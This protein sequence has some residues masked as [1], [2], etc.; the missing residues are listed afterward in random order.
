MATLPPK[1]PFAT[2]ILFLIGV[3]GIGGMIGYFNIPGEW[4]R[5]LKKPSFNPPDY[6]FGPVWTVLYLMIATAG[7]RVWHGVSAGGLKLLWA[8]QMGLNFLW[9]PVFFGHQNPGGAL[10]VIVTLLATIAAFM[11][12]A[13]RRDRVAALLFVPY[14]LWVGFATILNLRL[15]QLNP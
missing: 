5:E 11:A 3:V 9:S 10:V 8:L 4:Y 13:W 1:R 12:L 6:V 7:W 14:F 15:Y 2:L